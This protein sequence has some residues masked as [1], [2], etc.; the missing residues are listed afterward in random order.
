MINPLSKPFSLTPSN[1]HVWLFEGAEGG[2]WLQQL[3]HELAIDDIGGSG[4]SGVGDGV[5]ACFDETARS[6][7]AYG[8]QVRVDDDGERETKKQRVV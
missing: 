3:Q 8:R 7:L 2:K 4:E 5:S 6:T 1:S